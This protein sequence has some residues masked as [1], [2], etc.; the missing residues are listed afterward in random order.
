MSSVHATDA[1][2]A[3][4]R[5]IDMGIEPFLIAS[6]MQAVI[7]QRLVRRICASCR[8]R[9]APTAEE[10][11]YYVDSGG[12]KKTRFWKGEGCAR[13]A[14]TGFHG[15]IGVYE[16]LRVDSAI[17]QHIVNKAS[18]DEIRETAVDAGMVTMREHALD[19][20]ASDV[21]TIGEILRA[22]YVL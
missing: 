7:G 21:T 18:H 11:A 14:G 16:I 9:Y 19:L 1:A 4:H 15:R 3:V 5:F 17:K 8:V 12:R 10:L 13:C 2:A 22:I 6:A 20:V